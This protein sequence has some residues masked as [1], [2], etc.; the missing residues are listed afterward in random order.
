MGKYL[1]ENQWLGWK[2]NKYTI[3]YKG[4]VFEYDTAEELGQMAQE[5]AAFLNVPLQVQ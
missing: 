1:G 5:L 4:Y 3:E 2:I